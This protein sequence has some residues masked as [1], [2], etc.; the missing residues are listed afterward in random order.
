MNL[1]FTGNKSIREYCDE[2]YTISDKKI[3]E[4]LIIHFR[5]IFND[6]DSEELIINCHFSFHSDLI[7]K[8]KKT[9]I[10]HSPSHIK[11]S[12]ISYNNSKNPQPINFNINA[13]ISLYIINNNNKKIMTLSHVNNY[14]SINL[15][16]D[17]IDYIKN[18]TILYKSLCYV[19]HLFDIYIIQ[20]Y[21]SI[22]NILNSTNNIYNF[23]NLNKNKYLNK[24]LKYKEKYLSLK[25]KMKYK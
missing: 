24:Y 8:K 17:R 7:E 12:C 19:L 14:R 18:T 25:N 21:L 11:I 5:L 4:E 15:N 20:E 3:D 2:K 10:K 22:T 6:L 13:S 1:D 16:F 23:E 9:Y